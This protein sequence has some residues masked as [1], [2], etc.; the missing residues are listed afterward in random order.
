MDAAALQTNDEYDLWKRFIGGSEDAFA[1]IYKRYAGVLYNY[2][3][4]MTL[5]AS[6]VQDAIQDLFTDLWRTRQNLSETTSIKYYLFRAL[7]R[8]LHKLTDV[9]QL[10]ES[11]P[12]PDNADNL[13]V[14]LSHESIRIENEHQE[15]QI[16]ILQNAIGKLPE[17]QMEAIRLRF[18]EGFELKE[19]ADVMQMNEQSVRNLVQRSILNLRRSFEFL[20]LLFFLGKLIAFCQ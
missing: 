7:R 19:V 1:E 20:P 2:G 13:P 14:T 17:R 5:D 18:Y 12:D 4:H 16:R 6:L 9:K 3:Y 10:F 15:E 8:R 11:I